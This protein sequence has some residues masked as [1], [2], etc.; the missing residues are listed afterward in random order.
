MIWELLFIFLLIKPIPETIEVRITGQ[1]ACTDVM[2]YHTETIDFKDY[3]KG[4]L[5][6]EWIRTWPEESLKAGAFAV[7]QFAL[8]KNQSRGWLWDCNY[9]MV[10]DPSRRTPETDQAVNAI[11]DYVLVS[12]D[13]ELQEVYFDDYPNACLSRGQ[14][15]NCMSQWE[16]KKDAELGMT[17]KEIILKYYDG[18]LIWIPGVKRYYHFY[19]LE[20]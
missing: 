13:G 10:Y 18:E 9:D 3:V 19:W 16:T 2:T 4:V 12:D 20:R 1:G 15:E 5:P 6:A 17:W 14:T 11:W 8:V 7:R